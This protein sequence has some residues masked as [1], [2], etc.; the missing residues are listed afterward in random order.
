MPADQV[1][2]LPSDEHAQLARN[3][4]ERVCARGDFAAA[5]NYYNPRF[6]DHVN[7][8]NYSGLE[9][10]R[11]SVSLYRLVLPDLSMSVD[12]N[13]VVSRWTAEGTSRGRRVRIWGITIS[14]LDDGLIVEDWSASDN[15]GLVRQLGP[16]R[17][18]MVGLDWLRQRLG[19]R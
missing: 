13:R 3:A 18:A 14:H 4:T 8:L 9:G 17:A 6:V 2:S 1:T 19:K 10:V 7:D 12:G 16:W 11:Q 5:P 15:L